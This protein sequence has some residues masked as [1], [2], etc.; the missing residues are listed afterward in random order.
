G[1][2]V[3]EGS[4]VLGIPGRVVRRLNEE[5]LERVRTSWTAYVRYAAVHK[6]QEAARGRTLP[7]ART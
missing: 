3:P 7:E 4:L 6:R 2:H 1:W 5:D